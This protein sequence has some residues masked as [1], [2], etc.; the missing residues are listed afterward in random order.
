MA[1]SNDLLYQFAKITSNKVAAKK[2]TIVYGTVKSGGTAVSI[3][4]SDRLT[5]IVTAMSVKDG[6]RVMV[7]IK[8]HTAI[9]TS[10]ISSPAARIGTVNEIDG[11][12]SVFIDDLEATNIKVQTLVADNATITGTLN[13]ATANIDKLVAKNAEIEG[14]LTAQNGE[15]ENLKSKK[16]DAETVES[17][18]A[19]IGSLDAAYAEID[20]LQA[21]YGEFKKASVDRLD[22]HDA[23]IVDL[24]AK[25]ANIDDLTATVGKID[26]LMFGTAS[27]NILQ[28]DFANAVV[29]QLG[30]AQ[31]KSA[32]IDD[33]AASKIKS[34]DIITNNV[35]V[36]SED[37]SL[38]ISDETIQ[39]SDDNRV[40]VQIGK[41][42]SDDYS[43]NIWDAEG[44]LM[45]SEGGITDSA[46][47]NAI[48]RD[49]MVAENANI[50]GS[51]LN[52]DSLFTVMNNN[53]TQTLK[54][55]KVYLDE[56]KQTLDVSFKT[57]S[58]EVS[59]QGTA[60]SVIQGQITSKIWEQDINAATGEL[61]T[62]YSTL[63]QTIEGLTVE[64]GDAAKTATNFLK[65]DGTNSS[66][67]VGDMTGDAVGKNV[68]I[69]T[70]S[71]DIR[72][73]N[74]VLA[75]FG[76]KT[77]NL[78]IAAD[79]STINLCGG[80]GKIQLAEWS[81]GKEYLLFESTNVMRLE[82]GNS[83]EIYALQD[84]AKD[85]DSATFMMTYIKDGVTSEP[86]YP[87]ASIRTNSGTTL[88]DRLQG[89]FEVSPNGGRLS[90]DNGSIDI[91]AKT[92]TQHTYAD[93]QLIANSGRFLVNSENVD[94]QDYY[95]NLP[96]TLTIGS[97]KY[98]V[99]KVLWTGA[100]YM[101]ASQTAE[102]TD[103]ISNQPHGIVLLFS[104]YTPTGSVVHDT[105]VSYHFI[106]K[107]VLDFTVTTHNFTMSGINNNGDLFAEKI[108]W[109]RDS[110]IN[111]TDTNVQTYTKK[112]VTFNN[113]GFVLRAVIG[114]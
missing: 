32:M 4:G 94:I 63:T 106:P 101:Q 98:G 79:K 70:N 41:D 55:T 100:Y 28:T 14:T 103:L 88:N 71:I 51:K 66:L 112:G 52:V 111:G 19:T 25:T 38:L 15:I 81:S 11:R 50:S 16:I 46:I 114:V 108:L 104:P 21:D 47:K 110:E 18:Y 5:P 20:I 33:I 83:I 92:A 56:E 76:E 39:I 96:S 37:G 90:C 29:A 8:D 67:I 61:N 58:G 87:Y 2:E 40:R 69:D 30:D 31:I 82:A 107:Y 97:R 65:Y 59:S 27:G 17:R 54:S 95:V 99:N 3:D 85:Y 44:N 80:E 1:L 93:I 89:V 60:L 10:N 43:I 42:A 36:K 68:L 7:T 113:N 49:D 26:T 77:I 109:I 45:F 48:I 22:A 64:V 13:V 57:L 34:G 75:S 91:I 53:G 74:T 24:E 78:G 102:L 9:V 23:D 105:H 62:K 72:N 35:R 84:P 6:D 12:L 86:L 73:G